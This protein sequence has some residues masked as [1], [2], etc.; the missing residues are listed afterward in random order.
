RMFPSFTHS[1]FAASLALAML[2]AHAVD[3]SGNVISKSGAP[4]S[5]AKVCVKADASKCVTT[6][7]KGAFHIAVAASATAIR[8]SDPRPSPFAMDL[9]SGILT[10]DATAAGEVKVEWIGPG[11]RMLWPVENLRLRRGRNALT[12]PKGL[13]ESGICFLRLRAAGRT[14]TWKAVLIQGG[15]SGNPRSESASPS[16]RIAALAKSAGTGTLEISKTGYR[17]RIYEPLENPETGALIAMSTTDD[18]GLEYTGSF[19][20]KIHS[21]NRTAKSMMVEN[22][23]VYCEGASVVRDTTLDTTLYAFVGGKFWLWVKGECSGQVF[24]TTS[25]DPVGNF[26]LLDPAG[27]LPADLRVGCVSEIRNQDSPFENF[28]A[29]YQVTETRFSGDISVDLC[30]ADY[31]GF[32]FADPLFLDTNVSL[33]KNTCKQMIFENGAGETAALD[34]SKK[35]DSLW[36]DFTFK[37]K[38]C[39]GSLDF[40]LSGKDPVCPEDSGTVKSLLKC[41]LG[42]GFADTAGIGG[43]PKGAAKTSAAVPALGFGRLPMSRESAAGFAIRALPRVSKVRDPVRRGSIFPWHGWRIETAR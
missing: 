20:A 5:Q 30:P 13:P 27:E 33:T 29:N 23:D 9:R 36:F 34:F 21:I 16:G 38:K 22:V 10:L 43:A 1:A 17:T 25:T 11:G 42:S 2:P 7:L 4:I 37:D 18:V 41:M 39:V 40:R 26:T 35:G 32:Y 31:F 28:N 12:V 6:D 14:F 24:T 19:S 3:V 15:A 8:E